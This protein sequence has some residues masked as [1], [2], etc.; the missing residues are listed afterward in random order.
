MSLALYPSR[1][2]SSDVLGVTGGSPFVDQHL[3]LVDASIT[4][5]VNVPA[6]DKQPDVCRRPIAEA[7][8]WVWRY[9]FDIFRQARSGFV[10]DQ[11]VEA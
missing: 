10:I 2:R 11:V 3:A 1:V 9:V 5:E 4:D 8:G 6:F 7:T